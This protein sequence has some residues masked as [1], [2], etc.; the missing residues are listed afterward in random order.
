MKF[1]LVESL[2]EVDS[3]GNPLS[4]EQIE[5]FKNSKVRD[6]QGRLLA[7]YHSTDSDFNIFDTHRMG[8]HGKLFGNGFYFSTNTDH[9][10]SHG[11]K[12]KVVYL[13]VKK[14]FIYNQDIYNEGLARV[15]VKNY[16]G[17]FDKKLYDS[18]YSFNPLGIETVVLRYIKIKSGE[19]TTFTNV[20]KASDYDGII[21]GVKNVKP[22]DSYME[23][24]AFYANQIKSITN[25][26]PTNSYNINEELT[27]GGI[28]MG[29][30]W[31]ANIDKS[32]YSG[33]FEKDQLFSWEY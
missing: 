4:P 1:K 16:C 19:E 24:V 9:R 8:E 3:E 27:L 20:L 26:A 13:N 14:P 15:L 31:G 32:G 29:S 25:K 11:D 5:F 18:I 6:K 23:L 28:E 33:D 22:S 17:A 2:Q 30:G 7:C 10:Y 21:V 12:Y